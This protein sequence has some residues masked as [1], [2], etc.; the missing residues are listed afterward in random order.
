MVMVMVLF[1]TTASPL[2]NDPPLCL[3]VEPAM[4]EDSQVLG[5][6][7]YIAPEVILGAGYDR[8]VDWWS[9]GVILYEFLTGTTPFYGNTVEEIFQRTINDSVAFPDYED[10]DE[11]DGGD[12]LTR[13]VKDLI[14]LLLEKDPSRR[15]GTPPPKSH[16]PSWEE[17]MPGAFYVKEHDF[18][19][20]SVPGEETCI[21]WDN[22]LLDKANFVPML[23]DD[24]DTS[25]FDTREE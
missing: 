23:E 16:L 25:Y 15:L 21:D 9:M 5:T 22:L 4:P 2:Y 18:F 10:D 1:D 17:V 3:E 19:Y 13:E 8:A 24:M 20:N 11:D 6:P 7:D 14:L 12:A